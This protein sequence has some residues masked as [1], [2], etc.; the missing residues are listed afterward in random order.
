[1]RSGSCIVSLGVMLI[2]VGGGCGDSTVTSATNLPN[3]LI[4]P[5]TVVSPDEPSETLAIRTTGTVLPPMQGTWVWIAANHERGYV[6]I[7]PIRN[8]DGAQVTAKSGGCTVSMGLYSVDEF[9]L[10]FVDYINIPAIDCTPPANE[11]FKQMIQGLRTPFR[12]NPEND[13]L[14][15]PDQGITLIRN[16]R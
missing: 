2:L 10:T 5:T 14:E 8:H 6:S 15:L 4:T 9:L 12:Y 3:V 13:S 7:A 1:M 16:E 11:E